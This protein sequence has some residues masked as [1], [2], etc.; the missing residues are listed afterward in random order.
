[1][2][3]LTKIAK[4]YFA[5]TFI[6]LKVYEVV[7]TKVPLYWSLIIGYGV[8]IIIRWWKEQHHA[9]KRLPRQLHETKAKSSVQ[10]NAH[11]I[12]GIK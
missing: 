12:K 1:M 7:S 6:G 3:N 10:R 8:F 5:E 11:N 4:N 2:E 9:K